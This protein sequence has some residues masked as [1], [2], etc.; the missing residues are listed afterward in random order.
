MTLWLWL[1][2]LSCFISANVI[3]RLI[4]PGLH[5]F[6]ADV[7]AAGQAVGRAFL[8]PIHREQEWTARTEALT[9][10]Y[11]GPAVG[12]FTSWRYSPFLGVR[13]TG[14]GCGLSAPVIKH[15][16]IDNLRRIMDRYP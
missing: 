1:A 8:R 15:R 9:P 12:D 5:Q 6:G 3:G 11:P 2:V 16:E 4:A 13:A 10:G 7:G 14:P